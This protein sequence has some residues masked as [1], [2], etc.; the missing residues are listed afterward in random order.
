MADT[1]YGI[2][3]SPFF[4]P[5]TGM[6][7]NEPP[8][9]MITAINMHTQKVLWQHP[10]GSAEKNGPFGLPTE[11]P[12]NIGTPNNGGP[13]ITAGGLTFVAATTDNKIRAYDSNTGK[14][15]WS[16]TLPAGGQATPMTYSVGGKQYLV[17]MAGGHHFMR[18]NVGDYVIA[19]ALN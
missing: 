9:G 17:I 14:E 2:N 5:L 18:T 15:V 10:L 7:C 19:Y 11:L 1:P 13:V 6:L 3:V 4:A 12:I 16:D 8:Y